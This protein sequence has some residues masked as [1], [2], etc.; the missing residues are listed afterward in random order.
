LK[1]V[2]VCSN[3]DFGISVEFVTVP[4]NYYAQNKE[5]V[6]VFIHITKA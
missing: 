5:K 3:D 1:A 2:N 4:E 6:K